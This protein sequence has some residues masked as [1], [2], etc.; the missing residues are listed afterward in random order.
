LSKP[1][2]LPQVTLVAIDTRAP[3]LAA[4]SLWRSMAQVD[5]ARVV[6]FTHDW[7]D[8]PALHGIQ[9]VDCGVI[10][11]G[12]DYSAFVLRQLPAHIQTSH[13]LVTQWDGFVVDASAWQQEF[14]DYDYIGAVWPDQSDGMNVGNGGFSLRSRRLLNAGLDARIQQLHPEDL[15]LCRTYRE[16]LQTEHAVRFAPATLARQ[17]AFENEAPAQPTFGFHGPYNLPRVMDQSSLSPW[18]D[19]LPPEF[20][21]SRDARRLARALLA[22]RMPQLAQ[23]LVQRRMAAG[24]TDVN[25]RLL[26]A[27]ASAQGFFSKGAAQ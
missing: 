8:A 22:Q 19:A 27:L 13:V 15:M 12:P 24:R 6:L 3:G 10:Q 23:K 26:G 2:S 1:L 4:Q 5:F 21:R 20:F 9:V 11:S 17:F 18:L 16:L 7:Q 14:L 25:T